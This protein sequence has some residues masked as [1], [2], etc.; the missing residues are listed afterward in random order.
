MDRFDND[1]TLQKGQRRPF[2][3]EQSFTKN[4]GEGQAS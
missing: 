3:C 4:A 1:D 2:L